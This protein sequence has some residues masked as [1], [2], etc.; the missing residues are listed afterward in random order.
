M[1]SGARSSGT[2]DWTIPIK[3]AKRRTYRYRVTEFGQNGRPREAPF[4]ETDSQ[5]LVLLPLG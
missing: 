2:F 3:D 4:E 1:N 5:M